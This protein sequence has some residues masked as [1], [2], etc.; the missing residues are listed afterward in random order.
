M[1]N[2]NSEPEMLKVTYTHWKSGK[3]LEAIGTMPKELNNQVNDRV[4]VKH[5][6]G[7]FTDIIKTTIIRVEECD[8]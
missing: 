3:T 1:E 2:T 8:L 7:T 4:I 6:D 5:P